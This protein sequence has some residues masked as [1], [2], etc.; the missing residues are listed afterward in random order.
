MKINIISDNFPKLFIMSSIG[1][2]LGAF[3]ISGISKSKKR[4]KTE[5]NS[6][7]ESTKRGH[8]PKARQLTQDKSRLTES[9]L[10]SKIRTFLSDQDK[11]SSSEDDNFDSRHK[12]TKFKKIQSSRAKKS[13]RTL[14]VQS[15]N[16]Q[17]RGF[18][19]GSQANNESE[20]QKMDEL[21]FALVRKLGS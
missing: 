3:V 8:S 2:M 19:S 21:Y 11:I 16:E 18:N 10:K 12:F 13:V 15:D 14:A 4:E 9:L 6:K 17:P 5:E 1:V 7:E 20:N